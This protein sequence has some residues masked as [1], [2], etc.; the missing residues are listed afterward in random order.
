MN[1]NIKN[2]VQIVLKCK[3][4]NL[5]AV[6]NQ[7]TY[8]MLLSL[9][10]F[11]IFLMTLV[12]FFNLDV[13]IFLNELNGKIPEQIIGI[14]NLFISEVVM[15]KNI[16]LLSSSLFISIWS[17]SSGFAAMIKC[18]NKI[19]RQNETRNFIIVKL[20]SL[21]CVI[22]FALAIILCIVL[23]VFGNKIL[24]MVSNHS[25][26]FF[27]LSAIILRYSVAILLLTLFSAIIYKISIRCKMNILLFL[28][29][30]LFCSLAWIILSLAFNFY[31]NNF[32]RYSTIYGSIGSIFVLMIWLN[33]I[34][35]VLLI[36]IEINYCYNKN[37]VRKS[38]EK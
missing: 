21:V 20:I 8:K 34:I 37:E 36:G 14:V 26:I 10:P 7:L 28:P 22:I 30:A 4:D 12:A 13:N 1:D 2:V 16:S 33:L 17:A 18:I 6:A 24:D 29:G 27:S 35:N 32:S 23:I 31:V 11:I 15:K 5:N 25:L 3:N 19:Y 9:F 38:Y